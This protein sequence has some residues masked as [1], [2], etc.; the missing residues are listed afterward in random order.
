MVFCLK[1]DKNLNADNNTNSKSIRQTK[2]FV[3]RSLAE[4]Q[5]WINSSTY[6]HSDR[7]LRI[8]LNAALDRTSIEDIC[9]SNPEYPSPDTVMTMLAKT[10]CNTSRD[11]IEDQIAGLFQSQVKH[12]VMFKRRTPPKVMLAIDIHDEEYYGKHLY[13]GTLRLTMFSH[14]KKR[15]AL[16]FATLS[17]VLAENKWSY[18]LTI[19]LVINHL[20]Q[21]RIEVVKRLL[22][23]INLPMKIDCLLMDGGFNDAKIF[24][25]LDSKKINFLVRG[26]VSKK[27]R[28]P[29]KVGSNFAYKTGKSKYLVE[30]YLFSKRGKDGKLKFVLLLGSR[31]YRYTITKVKSLYRK[32]FRIENTYRHARGVKI[33]TSTSKIQLRW[34]MWAFAHFLEVIW[35]LIRYI[36]L[37]QDLP[38]YHCRQKQFIRIIKEQLGMIPSPQ[39][40]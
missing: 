36:Y 14:R 40:L 13:D 39:H 3:D 24:E 6:Y 34:I 23:Q 19:S 17:I 37:V 18:P 30:A 27:K 31:R 26:R 10:H 8:I 33:R 15:N 21:E 5:A 32:R 9:S 38:I 22:N 12:H 35:E 20:G 29:G 28:Y 11:K 2:K 7:L 25:Y 16:R 1:V 4:S